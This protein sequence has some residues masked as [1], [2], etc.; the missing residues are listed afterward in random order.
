MVIN[1]TGHSTKKCASTP[2]MSER[3]S[4]LLLARTLLETNTE[5]E[6]LKKKVSDYQQLLDIS[7]VTEE[8]QS[9]ELAALIRTDTKVL[10]LLDLQFHTKGHSQTFPYELDE[11]LIP[12]IEQLFGTKIN[13]SILASMGLVTCFESFE[14]RQYLASSH[15]ISFGYAVNEPIIRENKYIGEPRYSAKGLHYIAELVSRLAHEVEPQFW[16]TAEEYKVI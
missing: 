6:Q 9:L 10:S 13:N 14:Y 8:I 16:D 15:A 2:S 4:G 1:K 11:H 5:C 3:E 7:E 12:K